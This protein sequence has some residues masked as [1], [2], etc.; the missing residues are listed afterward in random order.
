M[1]T[2]VNCKLTSGNEVFNET[3]FVVELAN[4][5]CINIC[6]DMA[7]NLRDYLTNVQ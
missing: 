2:I 3:T 4:C 7:F 5:E 6:K 1:A